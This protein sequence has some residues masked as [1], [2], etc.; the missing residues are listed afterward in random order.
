[1]SREVESTQ[2]VVAEPQQ[3][4]IADPDMPINVRLG[5]AE[6]LAQ[7]FEADLSRFATISVTV[8]SLELLK[9]KTD[10]LRTAE[11]DWAN[12]RFQ[13]D[14]AREEWNRFSP[15]AYELHDELIH[16]YRYGYRK[17]PMI[18]LQIDEIEEGSSHDDM[19][20][21]LGKLGAIGVQYPDELVKIKF[22]T[23]KVE[24]A[25]QYSDELATLYASATIGDLGSHPKKV[26]RDVAYA[27]L[28]AIMDEI[29]D[30]G[31]YLFW[32][33]A[34]RKALYTSDYMSRKGKA[35]RERAKQKALMN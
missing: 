18:Q 34:E 35:A 30:A 15:L 19:L 5:E 8:E 25:I 14:E 31:K 9:T 1:M 26:A 7:V 32:K 22:P 3:I 17:K 33:D 12:H 29:R 11:I 28:K 10:A 23:T 16:A 2:S 4:I 13:K 27:E 24:L 21:D 6:S 20:L